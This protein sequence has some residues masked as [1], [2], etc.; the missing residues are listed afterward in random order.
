MTRCNVGQND[1]SAFDTD[2]RPAFGHGGIPSKRHPAQPQARRRHA[3]RSSHTRRGNDFGAEWP[4]I[5]VCSA[6]DDVQNAKIPHPLLKFDYIEVAA[7]RH[8]TLQA[9]FGPEAVQ[10][11]KLRMIY[12]AQIRQSLSGL[13]KNC[14]QTAQ[15]RG[16]DYLFY[17]LGLARPSSLYST[18]V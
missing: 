10:I 18:K 5:N 3:C 9:F 8:R 7:R 16:V 1:M 17:V 4:V 13:N 11:T 15:I 6:I 2:R 14:G 12:R